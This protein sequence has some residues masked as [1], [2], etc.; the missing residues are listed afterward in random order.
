MTP[1]ALAKLAM[2]VCPLIGTGAIVRYVPK[3]RNIVH[4]MTADRPV[5][6]RVTETTRPAP[7]APCIPAEAGTALSGGTFGGF[8]APVPLTGSVGAYGLP[9][10]GGSPVGGGGIVTPGNPASTIPTPGAVP[11]AATWITMVTGFGIV[12]SAIRRA[13]RAHIG[14]KL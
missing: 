9:S 3:A 5:P 8:V 12:G 13:P 14:D 1:A 2:C 7:V 11:E 4:R 6:A 10:G